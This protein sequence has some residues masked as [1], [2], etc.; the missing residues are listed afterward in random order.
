MVEIVNRMGGW[1]VK[2]KDNTGRDRDKFFTDEKK[3]DLFVKSL[4]KKWLEAYAE[5]RKNTSLFS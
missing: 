1:S 5:Y 2:Y 4:D 3:R